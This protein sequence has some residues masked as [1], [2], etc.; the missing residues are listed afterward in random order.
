MDAQ[1]NADFRNLFDFKIKLR[2]KKLFPFFQLAEW[3]SDWKIKICHNF[4]E[5]HRIWIFFTYLNS[6]NHGESI[7]VWFVH[8][9][10]IFMNFTF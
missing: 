10:V 7:D 8:F 9:E 2:L 5:S 4:P 6:T 3:I 1:F